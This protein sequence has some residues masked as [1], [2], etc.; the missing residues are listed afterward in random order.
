M[1]V[2][3]AFSSTGMTSCG[4]WTDSIPAP[5][6]GAYML[7]GNVACL[8]PVFLMPPSSLQVMGT[9]LPVQEETQEIQEETQDIPLAICDAPR[10]LPKAQKRKQ[11]AAKASSAF[12]AASQAQMAQD[13]PNVPIANSFAPLRFVRKNAP[14]QWHCLGF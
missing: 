7:F 8:V 5:E 14:T 10:P 4:H 1:Q 11:R 6:G 2:K 12:Q 13:M 9:P 3:M